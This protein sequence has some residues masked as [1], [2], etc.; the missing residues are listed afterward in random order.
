MYSPTWAMTYEVKVLCRKKR[1]TVLLPMK[2]KMGVIL[3]SILS[4]IIADIS[5][6]LDKA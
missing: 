3:S 4:F 2:L 5:Q 1:K 6:A